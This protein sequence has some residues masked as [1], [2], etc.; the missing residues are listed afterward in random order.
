MHGDQCHL[1]AIIAKA[2][3][4]REQSNIFKK[5]LQSQTWFDCSVFCR[6]I[7]KFHDIAKT[8]FP[9]ITSI[10]KNGAISPRLDGVRWDSMTGAWHVLVPNRSSSG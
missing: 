4:I 2:V 10:T 1:I 9:F 5:F 7:P 6:E 8:L 3:D